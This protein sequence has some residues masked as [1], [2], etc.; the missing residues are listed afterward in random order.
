MA[1]RTSGE[2]KRLDLNTIQ[3]TSPCSTDWDGMKGDDKTRFC[4]ACNKRVFNLSAMTRREAEVMVKETK[5]QFC[6]RVLRDADGSVITAAE[7]TGLNFVKLRASKFA[8]AV[9]SAALSLSP[10]LAATTNTNP[11][12]QVQ[13][14]KE[15]Q[16]DSTVANAQNGSAKIQGTIYDANAA[17]IIQAKVTLTN[18]KTKE[19]F[20]TFSTYEDGSYHFVSLPSGI[21]EFTVES[22][23]FT[24]HRMTNF[25]LQANI[26]KRMNVT[27]QVREANIGVVVIA[28]DVFGANSLETIRVPEASLQPIKAIQLRVNKPNKSTKFARKKQTR[29][30]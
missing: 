4:D 20:V 5:G 13:L 7:S 22:P 17:I 12:R 1:E 15:S 18:E 3:V 10:V 28:N 27:L 2:M 29:K 8:S 26:E 6:A 14:E 24:V 23:G 25:E 9:V 21:Y 30:R 19:Q 11:L 16:R